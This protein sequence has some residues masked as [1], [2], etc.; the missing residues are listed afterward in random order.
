MLSLIAICSQDPIKF[1]GYTLAS[2]QCS[3]EGSRCENC[4]ESIE[5]SQKCEST[6]VLSL[7]RTVPMEKRSKHEMLHDRQLRKHLCLV[8]LHHATIHLKKNVYIQHNRSHSLCQ[9]SQNV[10]SSLNNT[11]LYHPWRQLWYRKYQSRQ[12]ALHGLLKKGP[13]H[14]PSQS[15]GVVP[16]ALDCDG[17]CLG[18][19]WRKWCCTIRVL[20]EC[21]ELSKMFARWAANLKR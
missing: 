2:G 13:R 12:K 15:N 11:S 8:H 18:P 5:K 19:A 3:L 7:Q 10:R 9:N 20:S 4:W 14:G 1:H 17:P 21:Y 16:T 6:T